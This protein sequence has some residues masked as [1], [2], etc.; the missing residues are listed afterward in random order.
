MGLHLSG[1]I[2]RSMVLIYWIQIQSPPFQ[3]ARSVDYFITGKKKVSLR[4]KWEK[5]VE[6]TYYM[7]SLI[8]FQCYNCGLRWMEGMP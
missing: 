6:T 4:G 5:N 3:C 8:H 1:N 7:Y 2:L